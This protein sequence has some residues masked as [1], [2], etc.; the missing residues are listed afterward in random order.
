MSGPDGLPYDFVPASWD[1][2]ERK[3]AVQAVV[4]HLA[5]GCDPLGYLSGPKD[6]ILRG[7]SATFVV[8]P[9]GRVVQMLPLAHVS[10]SLNPREVRTSTEPD[11]WAGRRYTRFMDPDILDGWVNHRVWSIE[12]AGFALREWT[13]GDAS[14]PKMVMAVAMA[15]QGGAETVRP[16][17]ASAGGLPDGR[18]TSIPPK[19]R[20]LGARSTRVLG[21]RRSRPARP[22]RS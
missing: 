16:D 11:G 10:G 5:E 3:R 15:M 18:E 19:A 13:C 9:G 17:A 6:R 7:V 1:Y 22:V 12:C 2:G 21:L 14:S 8:Q 4:F 20:P